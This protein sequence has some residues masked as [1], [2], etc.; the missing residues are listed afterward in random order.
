[1]PAGSGGGRPLGSQN[2][3]LQQEAVAP[4]ALLINIAPGVALVVDVTDRAGRLLG[5]VYGENDQLQQLTPADAAAP[6]ESLEVTGFNMVYDAVAD[7]W[8][9][10]REGTVAGS[11]LVDVVPKG[12]I[13]NGQVTTNAG[14]RAALAGATPITSVTAKALPTNTGFVYVGNAT[15]AAGNGYI[16]SV[17]DSVSLDIDDLATVFIDVSVNAEGVSYIAIV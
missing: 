8:N 7:D 11:I 4:F 6:N 9:R 16:L 17:N 10:V 12:T 15:V 3:P 13:L 1:M 14:V 5:I 2:L